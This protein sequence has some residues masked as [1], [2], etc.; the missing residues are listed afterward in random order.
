MGNGM[1]K[2][3]I[4]MNGYNRHYGITDNSRMIGRFADEIKSMLY[5]MLN[6]R[7]QRKSMNWD[8]YQLSLKKHPLIRLKIY[9]YLR[10]KERNLLYYVLLDILPGCKCKYRCND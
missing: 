2:L 10:F 8:K 4:K 9:K 1:K 5:K 3:A 6:K 7:S